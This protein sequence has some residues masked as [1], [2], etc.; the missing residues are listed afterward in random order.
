MLTQFLG[1]YLLYKNYVD[2]QQLQKTLQHQK[3]SHT[4]IG[5]LAVNA[6]YLTDN[7]VEELHNIQKSQD[8]KIGDIAIQLGYLSDKQVQ[9]LL[10]FQRSSHLSLGQ[11]LIKHG[12]IS[13]DDFEKALSSYMRSYCLTDL[14]FCCEKGC[15]KAKGLIEQFYN[16]TSHNQSDILTKYTCLLMKNLVRFI[17]SDFIPIKLMP[18]DS[19]NIKNYYF[20]DLTGD[21]A[22]H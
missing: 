15:C 11:A 6:G 1:S 4:K 14:D 2:M 16:Y 22:V 20:Q 17:G 12:L 3:S 13:S 19:Y 21:F 7:Q 9:S 10:A 8:K 5:T 18:A